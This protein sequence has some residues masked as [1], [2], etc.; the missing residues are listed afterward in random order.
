MNCE[1]MGETEIFVKLELEHKDRLFDE[2]NCV[3]AISKE[4]FDKLSGHWL[5]KHRVVLQR[6]ETA[7]M[8]RKRHFSCFPF[9]ENQLS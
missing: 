1:K 7:T 6:R 4:T 5:D 3:K 9:L 2:V 8:V